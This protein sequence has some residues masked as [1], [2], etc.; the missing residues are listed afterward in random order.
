[1]KLKSLLPTLKE[2]KRYLVFEIIKI[3]PLTQSKQTLTEIVSK[4]KTI[5]GVFESANAGILGVELKNDKGILRVNN[6][7]VDKTI[8]CMMLIQELNNKKTIIKP[9]LTTGLLDK[10]RQ[11]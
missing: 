1:M 2:K 9:L 4:I 5:L 11:I 3:E 7:Y 6:N 10:A 8:A